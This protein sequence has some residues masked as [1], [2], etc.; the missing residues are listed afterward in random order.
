M[1]VHK[2]L[3]LITPAQ[4]ELYCPRKGHPF[5][6]VIS[7]TVCDQLY[8]SRPEACNGLRCNNHVEAK[9]EI[10]LIKKKAAIEDVPMPK[11]RRVKVLSSG[12]D[13]GP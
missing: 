11:R 9:K 6:A 13:H 7:V 8:E 3:P 1:P 10:E 2:K 4:G 12:A 5:P